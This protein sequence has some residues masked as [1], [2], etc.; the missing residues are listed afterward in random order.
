[1]VRGHTID[2]T[3]DVSNQ[4]HGSMTNRLAI[5]LLTVCGLV[6]ACGGHETFNYEFTE[7]GCDTGSQDFDSLAAMCT[8]L[9]S[10]AVNHSCALAARM[11]FFASHC[12][13]TFTETP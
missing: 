1:M 8:A 2:W 9:Q 11:S 13:G 10:D 7:N 4:Y 5:A 3:R 12:T 6:G